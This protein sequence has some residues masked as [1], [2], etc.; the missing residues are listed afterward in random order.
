ME[1]YELK[2]KQ[3]MNQHNLIYIS[4]PSVHSI[5]RIYNLLY[6]GIKLDNYNE[7]ELLYY[8]IVLFNDRKSMK[9][10]LILKSI[11]N[12]HQY[13]K[14]VRSEALRLIGI[15]KY[16][17]NKY[18]ESIDLINRSIQLG[19]SM[20]LVN[21]GWYYEFGYGNI[22]VDNNKAIMYYTRSI[23]L[24][25]P[26]G[27]VRLARLYRYGYGVPKDINKSIELY[28][29]AISL[30]CYL[31]YNRL[32]NL[33]EKQKKMKEAIELYTIASM[34]NDKESTNRLIYIYKDGIY[35]TT[36]YNKICYY[37]SLLN[38][39]GD[40]IISIINNQ[41]SV[42][43]TI[44]LHPYWISNKGRGSN[45]LYKRR[46]NNIIRILL[47]ISKY[48]RS[49]NIYVLQSVMIKGIALNVIKYVANDYMNIK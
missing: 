30:N 7:Y 37:Y 19:N 48:R 42:I 11:V 44:K 21:M 33:Y 22:K 10:N 32:G 4:I 1:Q 26:Y 15:L 8:G 3:Y 49:S 14:V 6:K 13:N 12:N 35:V 46:F 34:N 36:D 47:L 39:Q 2:I 28:R 29:K 27:M 20:S 43:W 38:D 45:I 16:R 25:N 17:M 18:D 5:K 24:N 31:A 41:P 40:K 23:Q 9:T